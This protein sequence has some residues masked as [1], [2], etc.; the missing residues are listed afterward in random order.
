MCGRFNTKFT[1]ELL[2]KL[3]GAKPVGNTAGYEG[4]YNVAITEP[5]PIIMA[6]AD[7]REIQLATFG[8]LPP[9][10]VKRP[11]LFNLQS[12]KAANRKDFQSQ[13]CIIPAVGFYEW[14]KV[15]PT[16][17]QPYYFSPKDSLFSF[18]GVWSQQAG[19][20]SF[21][22]FTTQPNELVSPIHDRM[23]VILSPD[24]IDA[25]LDNNSPNETLRELMRPFPANGMQVWQVSKAVNNVKNKEAACINS[26]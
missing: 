17:K 16:D 2:E 1:V 14:L 26:L 15:T 9:A 11:P 19:N 7:K 22:I 4:S 13:R 23:P 21:S 8:T 3:Y 24:A 18:A 20:L 10:G 12:E 6:Q 5:A 25:W